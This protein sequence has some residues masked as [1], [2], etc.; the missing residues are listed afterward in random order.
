MKWYLTEAVVFAF[1]TIKCFGACRYLGS[2]H[3]NNKIITH[4]L[5]N[6][7]CPSLYIAHTV[8]SEAN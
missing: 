7:H 5:C 3:C 8:A 4:G 2:E 6:D 1:Q